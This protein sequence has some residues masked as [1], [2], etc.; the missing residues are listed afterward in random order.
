MGPR[1]WIAAILLMLGCA[2]C[3]GDHVSADPPEAPFE[4]PSTSTLVEGVTLAAGPYELRALQGVV[5]SLEAEGWEAWV[6][7]V[8]HPIGSDP[9]SGAAVGIWIVDDV[10][11]DPCNWDEG[12]IEPPVGLSVDDLAGALAG[13]PNVD[14]SRPQD[15][16]FEGH[17]GVRMTV[18]VPPNIR[19]QDCADSEYRSW[20][21]LPYG[22]RYHQGPGQIDE[23]WILDVDGTRVVIEAA[24]FP[25]TAPEHRRELRRVVESIRFI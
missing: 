1:L 3:S 24:Y 18:Q 22:G 16:T 19:F 17:E 10:Y 5:P 23:L 12:P 2:G 13:R 11:A 20:T 15:V 25:E 9:P 8:I 7:G 14:A 4:S 21:A 6:Y